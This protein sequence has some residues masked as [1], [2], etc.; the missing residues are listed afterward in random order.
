M[1]ALNPRPVGER[2]EEGPAWA[3]ASEEAWSADGAA[4]TRYRTSKALY[5]PLPVRAVSRTPASC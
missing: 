2:T 4:D 1:R 3:P 5:R